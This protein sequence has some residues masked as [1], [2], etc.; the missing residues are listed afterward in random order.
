LEDSVII[1]AVG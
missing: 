1:G